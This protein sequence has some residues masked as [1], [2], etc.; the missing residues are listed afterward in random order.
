MIIISRKHSTVGDS[1]MS[2]RTRRIIIVFLSCASLLLFLR[3]ITNESTKIDV[4]K[5]ASTALLRLYLVGS[6]CQASKASKIPNING[7]NK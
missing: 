6:S 4:V 3:V 1:I 5:D 2:R 7:V